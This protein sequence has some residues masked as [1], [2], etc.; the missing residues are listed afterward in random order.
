MRIL[1]SGKI[2]DSQ[3]IVLSDKVVKALN[4][5]SGDSSLFY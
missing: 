3:R 2:D 4:V 1:G 5:K